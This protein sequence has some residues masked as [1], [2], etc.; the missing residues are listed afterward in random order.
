MW[1]SLLENRLGSI[2]HIYLE[3]NILV[4]ISNYMLVLCRDTVS[5]TNHKKKKKI[6]NT[7]NLGLTSVL[8][9]ISPG[10]HVESWW[11]FP[12]SQSH[13]DTGCV[14]NELCTNHNMCTDCGIRI[15]W[16]HFIPHWSALDLAKALFFFPL[17]GCPS[18]PLDPSIRSWRQS[19]GRTWSC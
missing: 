5:L 11:D 13:P 1:L 12:P 7:M 2:D 6:Q 9:R 8:G 18:S 19:W 3:K 15:R 4:S 14:R 17:T 16:P 10:S